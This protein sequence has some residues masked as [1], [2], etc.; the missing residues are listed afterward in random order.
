M[1]LLAIE[2][3]MRPPVHPGVIIREHH[4]AP[5]SL[6]ITALARILGVSRKTASKIING[7]GA[8]TPAMALRL[9]RAF[10]TSPELWLNLQRNYDLWHAAQED[11]GWRDIQPV[12][13][14]IASQKE[15]PC[16]S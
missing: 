6:S 9:A 14:A 13:A 2:K 10:D 11:K 5:L 15:A 1:N 7:R 8:V 16:A 3:R 4:L 12:A